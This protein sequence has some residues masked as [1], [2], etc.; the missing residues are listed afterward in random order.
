MEKLKNIAGWTW[1][2]LKYIIL[3]VVYVIDR[4]ICAISPFT[5]LPRFML[6]ATVKDDNNEFYRFV[7]NSMYRSIYLLW[8][9]LIGIESIP[10][11]I[12]FLLSTVLTLF[13]LWAFF[14]LFKK[15]LK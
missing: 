11:L 9:L 3:Y 5:P 10:A 4:F 12:L 7:P 6:W 2:I 15:E 14:K 1:F 13:I 8:C